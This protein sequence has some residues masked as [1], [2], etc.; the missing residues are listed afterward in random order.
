M[1][2]K[3]RRKKMDVK[4]MYSIPLW[5]ERSTRWW[6]HKRKHPCFN[7][8]KLQT[9]FPYGLNDWRGDNFINWDVHVLVRSKF[10]ALSRKSTRISWGHIHKLGT[11]VSTDT[12]LSKFKFYLESKYSDSPDF[13]GIIFCP[14]NKENLNKQ[15]LNGS[16]SD[17]KYL[18]S[19]HYWFQNT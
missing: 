10:P 13:C 3:S 16:L 6:L 18:T 5:T 19:Q 8:T 14:W 1:K 7:K 4:D 9:V 11:S 15:L 2:K 12:F 17:A